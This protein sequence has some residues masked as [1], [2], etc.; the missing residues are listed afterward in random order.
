MLNSYSQKTKGDL[1]E[2]FSMRGDV[3]ECTLV[4]WSFQR[5]V[6]GSGAAPQK[7]QAK[8]QA[9]QELLKALTAPATASAAV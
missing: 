7:K 9:A 8:T 3:W 5:V 2:R 4:Y 1:E 6:N